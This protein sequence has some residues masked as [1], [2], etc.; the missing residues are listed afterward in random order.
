MAEAVF[1]NVILIPEVARVVRRSRSHYVRQVG[2]EKI[3]I[4]RPLKK[5]ITKSC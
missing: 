2:T 5:V 3:L 4:P 1:C